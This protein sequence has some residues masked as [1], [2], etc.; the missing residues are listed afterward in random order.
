MNISIV[1]G[2]KVSQEGP[3]FSFL[4][5]GLEGQQV[6]NIPAVVM[7]N[8]FCKAHE[9]YVL[10]NNRLFSHDGKTRFATC[11]AI[12]D[13]DGKVLLVNREVQQQE[14]INHGVDLSHAGAT[15]HPISVHYKLGQI[16]NPALFSVLGAKITSVEFAG[17]AVE[18]IKGP[19]ESR[20]IMPVWVVCTDFNSHGIPGFFTLDQLNGITMTAKVAVTLQYLQK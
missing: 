9:G 12:L 17:Y 1:A 13:K 19:N 14:I 11:F 8:Y 3:D 20:C 2:Q 10:H 7:C 18:E 6:G 4:I 15:L 5:S 16:G